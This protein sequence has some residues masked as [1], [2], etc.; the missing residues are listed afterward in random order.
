VLGL[1]VGAQVLVAHAAC[2]LE[3]LVEARH[4]EDLL[5][6]L[7]RLRQRIPLPVVDATRHD[8]VARA[9]RRR[10]DQQRRL[11]LDE[12][13]ARQVEA[14]LERGLVAQ[15]DHVL[16]ARPAQVEVAVLEP[17]I[18]A[19]VD[20]VGDRERRR[21]GVIEDAQLLDVDLDR[22]G[23]NGLVDRVGQALDHLPRSASPTRSPG[24]A[25]S[26]RLPAPK[27]RRLTACVTP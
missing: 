8:V 20:V 21:V 7:R 3:I 14:R 15:Q 12:A 24:G 27:R 6:D 22:T 25:P 26:R 16:E 13:P 19:H 2:E 5:V 17:Q 9:F 1:A 23:R 18:L 4:H 10:L 11:D